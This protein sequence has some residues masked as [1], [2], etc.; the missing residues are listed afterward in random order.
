MK[1]LSEWTT[2]DFE[3]YWRCGGIDTDIVDELLCRKEAETKERCARVCD[4]IVVEVHG[5]Q[6]TGTSQLPLVAGMCAAA[7]REMQ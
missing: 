4:A 5:G 3:L 6:P 7:I 1:P 2:E